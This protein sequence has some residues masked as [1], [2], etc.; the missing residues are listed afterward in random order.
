M[1]FSVFSYAIKDL[2]KKSRISKTMKF[3]YFPYNYV[4]SIDIERNCLG[5]EPWMTHSYT[6]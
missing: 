1:G 6:R 3:S 4:I 2:I 5:C